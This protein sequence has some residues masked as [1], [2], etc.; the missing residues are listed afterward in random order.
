[1]PFSSTA[2]LDIR[3]PLS[4]VWDAITKPEIVKQYFF[5]TNLVTDWNVGSPIFFRGEWEG[6]SYEDRGTVLSYE[7][8]KGLSFNYWSNFS[9]L[10][11]TPALRQIIRYDLATIHDGTRITIH[12]SNVDTQER[13]DHSASNWRSV[14]EGLKQLLEERPAA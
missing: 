7:P 4:S 8:M 13:A 1:M 12:Q 11:D 9:G 6:K 10:E 5:G 3:A 14:L 2:S